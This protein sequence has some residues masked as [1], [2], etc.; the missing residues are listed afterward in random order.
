MKLIYKRYDKTN[1]QGEVMEKW[2][3]Y[4]TNDEGMRD[5]D[6]LVWAHNKEEA[7]DLYKQCFDVYNKECS[8]VAVIGSDAIAYLSP[9]QGDDYDEI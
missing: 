7:I 2:M 8:V 6:E 5:G 1:T 9:Q 4:F 3:V